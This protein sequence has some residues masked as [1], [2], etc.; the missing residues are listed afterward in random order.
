MD[1][2]YY[3]Y[4]AGS[5]EHYA[6]YEK[7][8][9]ARYGIGF[10]FPDDPRASYEADNAYELACERYAESGGP[11][12][13]TVD[14]DAGRE[15]GDRYTLRPGDPDIEAELWLSRALGRRQAA[16]SDFRRPD[17]PEPGT[18]TAGAFAA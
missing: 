14:E 3:R 8:F 18:A 7:E 5:G 4:R 13:A 6:A 16:E 9:I 15:N 17:S 12:N 10:P 1:D 11:E 2:A